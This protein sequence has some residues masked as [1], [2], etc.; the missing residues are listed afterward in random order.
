MRTL[1][2]GTLALTASLLGLGLVACSDNPSGPSGSTGLTSAQV[3]DVGAAVSD[4]NDESTTEFLLPDAGDPFSASPDFSTAAAPAGAAFSPP[5]G[6]CPALDPAQPEDPDLDHIPT[7]LTL[8]WDP[9]ICSRTSRF[10]TASLFGSR[11]VVDPFPDQA[12]FDRDVTLTGLG[13][14]ASDNSG[15]TYKVTRD[16]TRSVRGSANSLIGTEDITVA[17]QLTG[18][19]DATVHKVGTLTFTPDDGQTLQVGVEKPSGTIT[20]DGTLTWTAAD[21]LTFTV[22]TVTPLHYN[23]SDGSCT[24][25]PRARRIDA[26]ELHYTRTVNGVASPGYLK[27]VWSACG[28]AP[29]RSYV[30]N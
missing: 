5:S 6:S 18:K 9:Q 28:Q 22:T 24:A 1:S 3:A 14:Q 17:R 11:G 26:G 25:L 13:F 10:G 12:G 16:G 29:A 21:V 7:T 4:E 15:N 23:N 2:R 19:H 27:V 20:V 30:A 8:S